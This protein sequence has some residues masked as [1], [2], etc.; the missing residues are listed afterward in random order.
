MRKKK[1]GNLS[2]KKQSSSND[3]EKFN[4]WEELLEKIIEEDDP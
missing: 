1:G 2:M 4:L 3:T